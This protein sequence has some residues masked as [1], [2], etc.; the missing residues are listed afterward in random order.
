MI[1]ERTKVAMAA[2]RERGVTIGNAQF[3]EANKTAA[4]ERAE[5]LRPFFTRCASLGMSAGAMARELNE[6]EVATPTGA[7]WSAKTVLRVQARI[8][9]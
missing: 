2:A 8:A 9:A 3:G 5:K 6:R 4:Q 1:S 7:K